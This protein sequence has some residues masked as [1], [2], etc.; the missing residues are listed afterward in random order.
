[1]RDLAV[2]D[3]GTGPALYAGGSFTHAS[4]VRVEDIARWDGS[5]W[6]A[7]SG[8]SGTGV[9]AKWIEALAVFDHGIGSTLYAGGRIYIAGGLVSSF[10][11]AWKCLPEVIFA[12]GFESG[13]TSAWSATAP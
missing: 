8:P 4:G 10:F 5:A 3:D 2:Y 11:A 9:E 13:D 12:D 6:S 7:L 1:V